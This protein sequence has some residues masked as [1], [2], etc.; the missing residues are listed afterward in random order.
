MRKTVNP[1][2]NNVSKKIQVKEMFNNIAHKYDFL[3]HFL[4]AGID[5]LWRKKAV[6]LLKTNNPQNILDIATGTGDFAIELSKLNPKKIIGLRGYGLKI[7]KRVPLVI[8]PNTINK[9]YL[10][11]KKIKLGHKLK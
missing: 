10:K 8:K 2:S 9:K 5:I 3:N 1:Y 6:K 4:S 11:T 7:N